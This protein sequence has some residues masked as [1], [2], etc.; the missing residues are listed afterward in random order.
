MHL[1]KILSFVPVN[2]FRNTIIKCITAGFLLALLVFI[3]T[4]K[5]VHHHESIIAK[6][7]K[8]GISTSSNSFVCSI[9]DYVFA[10]DAGLPDL[11]VINVLAKFKGL[12]NSVFYSCYITS[13]SSC[14]ADRGPPAC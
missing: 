9:C 14:I 11:P 4:E 1:L 8:E 6:T 3:H 5:A 2:F 10:K 12:D 13:F 7:Q